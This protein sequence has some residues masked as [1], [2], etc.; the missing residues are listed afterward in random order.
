MTCA[1][2]QDIIKIPSG[3]L[4]RSFHDCLGVRKGCAR[5]V[6]HKEQ[7]RGSLAD[8]AACT[9]SL[10]FCRQTDGGGPQGSSLTAGRGATGR[11]QTVVSGAGLWSLHSS[12]SAPLQGGMDGEYSISFS[13]QI[14]AQN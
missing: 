5:W 4:T 8:P 9:L 13:Y 11:C 6:P 3:S 7:K 14:V 2:I 12:Y 1:E 10:F